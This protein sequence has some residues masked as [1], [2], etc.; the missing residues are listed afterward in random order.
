MP[1][2]KYPEETVQIIL[3]AALKLFLEKGYEQTTIL[4]I[5]NEMGGLTRG[6]FYH[7]FKSKEE[8]LDALSNQLYNNDS[9]FEK[10]EKR[11]DLN[12]LEKLKALLKDSL[13]LTDRQKISMQSLELLRSP[14]FLKNLVDDNRD[15]VAPKYQA[16]IEEGI[17]DGSIKTEY[18]K[19]LAELFTIFTN[20]W[21]IPTIYPTT[22]EDSWDRL[23]VTK[24]VFDSMGLPIFDDEIMGLFKENT[25]SEE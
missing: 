17:E 14:T 7:H 24:K 19:L 8:V 22:E 18:P 3:D 13:I 9:P 1:R 15:I 16:I 23:I 12:G 20:F 6:A 25:E 2:N 4:D 21:M 11:K 5:V 10:V